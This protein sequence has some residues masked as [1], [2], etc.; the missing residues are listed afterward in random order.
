MESIWAG[1]NFARVVREAFLEQMTLN[2]ALHDLG[3]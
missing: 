1:V 3:Y 2:C